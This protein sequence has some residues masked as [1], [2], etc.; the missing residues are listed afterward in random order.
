[1]KRRLLN[2]VTS[3]SLL[4]CVAAVVMVVLTGVHPFTHIFKRNRPIF[5]EVP[6]GRTRYELYDH[7]MCA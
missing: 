5:N 1:M 7:R 6:E 2:L 3:L 4:L